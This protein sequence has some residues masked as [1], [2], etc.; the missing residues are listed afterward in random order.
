MKVGIITFPGSN[1]NWDIYHILHDY[2]PSHIT[3]VDMLWYA[4]SF[5]NGDKYDLLVLPG[6]FSYGDYLR[7][8][9]IACFTPLM[10]E[11]RIHAKAGRSVLGICNGFQ[12]LC[13]AGFLP[14]ALLRNKNLKH[15][16]KDVT[17]RTNT[18]NAF[19]NSLNKNTVY[20]IPISHS[21]GNYY[22]ESDTLKKLKDKNQIVFRY[23][24]N[25]N[26]SCADIAG[27]SNENMH[28]IGMMPHPE[29]AVEPLTGRT[30]GRAIFQS[31]F[32]AL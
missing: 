16:C 21:D 27:I 19:A 12:I 5:S 32:N 7:P 10:K 8:G 24:E 23:T 22:A 31:I 30:D 6:G 4:D 3:Q 29:R 2:F 1:C 13:E 28:I 14:G 9:A 20:Q 18:Q 26:G 15:I 25:P 11:L 17:L